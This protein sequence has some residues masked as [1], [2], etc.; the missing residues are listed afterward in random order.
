M[1]PE[2]GEQAAGVAKISK[3]IAQTETKLSMPPSLGLQQ[4]VVPK[5]GQEGAQQHLVGH[6]EA[7][8]AALEQA[9]ERD[10]CNCKAHRLVWLITRKRSRQRWNRRENAM[11]ACALSGNE[12]SG[13]D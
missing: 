8:A 5:L 13:N 2:L 10:A 11:P 4:L 12:S 6:Q 1:V 3:P 9:R 7:L